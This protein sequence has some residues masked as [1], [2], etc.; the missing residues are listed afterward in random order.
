MNS[1]SNFEN[2]NIKQ[3]NKMLYNLIVKHFYQ[4]IKSNA[5]L[6][7]KILFR[8]CKPSFAYYSFLEFTFQ[9]KK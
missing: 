8:K 9:R 6:D 3:I 7:L 5:L 4:N 1:L 2:K